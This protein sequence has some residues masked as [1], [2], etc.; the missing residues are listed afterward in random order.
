MGATCQG[1]GMPDLDE[2][3]RRHFGF[4]G[5][6]PGQRE[7]ID[8]TSWRAA[9]R[10]RSFPP[11]AASRCA[12]SC[13]RC[14]SP[15]HAGR[16]AADRADEGPDR[17]PR[18]RAASRPPGST[19]RSVAAEHARRSW[20][21]LRAGPL[22]LLY[23]APERFNNERFRDAARGAADRRCSRSTRPTASRSGA[24]TSG[25]T[26]SSSPASRAT[27]RRRARAGAH[28]HRHA[29]G[30]STTSA[31]ASPSPPAD[32]VAH[33]LLPPE[34]RRCS[35]RPCAA[36]RA[37]R[38]CCSS[39]SRAPRRA[40]PSST[41]RCSRRPRR[42]PRGCRAAG[43]SARAPTT[44]AWTTTGA[45]RG[46]GLVHGVRPTASSW[47]PSPSAWASTRPTSATSITTT[48][49]RAWRTTPRRSAAPAA[50]ARRRAA[51]CWPA[52]TTCTVLENFAYGD[53][54]TAPAVRGAARRAARRATTPSSASTDTACRRAATSARWCCARCSPTSSSRATWPGGTPLYAGYRVQ[55]ARPGADP[56]P[57]RRAASAVPARCL[58]LAG[59][60]RTWVHIDVDEAAR[61]LG[62]ARE[63]VVARPRLARRAGPRRAGAP[64]R[65]PP[66]PR[67]CAPPADP[68]ALASDAARRAACC[69]R[70]RDRAPRPGAGPG[71]GRR[72]PG[73]RPGRLFRRAPPASRAATARGA[74]AARPRCRRE[75][76]RRSPPTRCAEAAALAAAHPAALGHPRQRA[77]FLCGLTS[78]ALS[79]ARLAR[80]P[81]LR[82]P[83]RG[84][85]RRRAGRGRERLIAA[86]APAARARR[87]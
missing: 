30:R 52:P 81:T 14:C 51:R 61:G 65:A 80:H 69:A 40:R 87:R 82:R 57:L 23:V 39:G 11:A 31:A 5:L 41:S 79:A 64:G 48:C 35:P 71:R 78:P 26:T 22:R 16:L 37:R 70:A 75:P 76:P 83:G 17:R 84:P 21:T 25:P 19:R 60:S 86:S 34:P 2:L 6:P 27:L 45:R 13:R 67:S 56:R 73:A 10:R 38:S 7:V 59:G 43:L 63:R 29:A 32:A 8:A 44:P 9:R 18:A 72:L 28:R 54:P 53:T 33:R 49:P 66:L 36:A 3:A 24:T 50:T 42:S 62:S 77:R 47:P 1:P 20:T 55:A 58:R 12:T 15:A 46:A 68:G 74:G 85:L 4:A